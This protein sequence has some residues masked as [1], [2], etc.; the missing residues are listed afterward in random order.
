[1]YAIVCCL[2]LP[3]LTKAQTDINIQF[4][5]IITGAGSKEIK[6]LNTDAAGNIYIAGTFKGI[7]DFDPGQGVQNIT[8]SSIDKDIFFAKYTSNGVYLFAKR[9]GGANNTLSLAAMDVDSAG[10]IYIC[11]SY[12]G[13][14]DFDPGV[15]SQNLVSIAETED[16]FFA[17]YNSSGNYIFANSIGGLD[18][19][20]AIVIKADVVGNIYLAG[21]IV[22][23]ADFDPA[24]GTLVFN[25]GPGSCYIAKYNS[26][27]NFV[28]TKLLRE[29]ITSVKSI[30]PVDN[31][32]LIIA[33]QFKGTLD[34]PAQTGIREIRSNG[35]TS[36]DILLAKFN[37]TGNYIFAK[38][39][40]G[41]SQDDVE[42]MVVDASGNIYI[43]GEFG[44]TADFN[45]SDRTQNLLAQTTVANDID[46]FF[47]KYNAA[48][49]Y[50]LARDIGNENFEKGHAIATDAAGNIYIAGS[51]SG[52]VDF[53][54]DVNT[55]NIASSGSTD[56]FIARYDSVANYVFARNIGG[57]GQETIHQL[58]V[59]RR[60]NICMAGS[61]FGSTDLAP[62]AA[63]FINATS[64]SSVRSD[65]FFTRFV[66]MDIPLTTITVTSN[67]TCAEEPIKLSVA[68]QHN[69]PDIQW[70]WYSGSCDGTSIGSGN[71]IQV[72][73]GPGAT[74]YFVKGRSNC[75]QLGRC[76]TL[77]YINE[78]PAGERTFISID[79]P[80]PKEI[81]AGTPVTFTT[82]ISGG[83]QTPK[84]KWFKN[85][86]DINVNTATYTDSTLNNGDSVFCF[87][88][89]SNSCATPKN[90]RSNSIAFTVVNPGAPQVT[91][92]SNDMLIFPEGSAI[93][94]NANVTNAGSNRTLTYKWI[95]NG[96]YTNSVVTK[97]PSY[98]GSFKNNYQLTC[99][100]SSTLSCL[101]R[102]NRVFPIQYK[103]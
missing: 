85:N 24:P 93:V 30:A 17:K 70:L 86:R 64:A 44:G 87:L 61:F 47:A 16:A 29:A 82:K 21:D 67:T 72:K 96:D 95:I 3:F 57:S 36:E 22:S 79:A 84:Y 58:K 6:S 14:P 76:A 53:D 78:K 56:A 13:A 49:E 41:V 80:S 94:I 5:R 74:N 99:E 65:A 38:S 92:S 89:T 35:T 91:L 2:L 25:A 27:G 98:K 1:M 45:P 34:F 20:R 50:V 59:D 97:I 101:N 9:I 75:G 69:N 62:C 73:A 100:V 33:A 32:N 63:D 51:F 26:T 71:S 23:S 83:G 4:A 88:T 11:G 43:T 15:E 28:Y 55:I 52:T 103:K 10:N 68:P 102:V 31:G 19:Q 18:R 40:G 77:Q 66:Q 46:I 7:V 48:G 81:C 60:N 42:D 37:S 54:P 8:S 12:S 39:I 90:T